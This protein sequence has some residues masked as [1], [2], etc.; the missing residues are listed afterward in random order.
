MA[1]IKDLTALNFDETIA[2][3]VVM[4]DFWAPWCNPCKM[5]GAILEKA[6]VEAPAEV[7]IGKVNVEEHPELAAKYAVTNIPRIF[8][9]S[10]GKM[11]HDVSGVQSKPKLLELIASASAQN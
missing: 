8:V 6:A 4:V 5:L 1:I 10:D 2:K 11:V 3:G 9:F 7:I